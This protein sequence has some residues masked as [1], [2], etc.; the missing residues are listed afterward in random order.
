MIQFD[1]MLNL[2]INVRSTNLV[3]FSFF[4]LQKI[5]DTFAVKDLS[6]QIV[7][8]E[9]HFSWLYSPPLRGGNNGA[10]WIFR[11]TVPSLHFQPRHLQ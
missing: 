5:L 1:S 4:V 7:A 2:G 9:L 8:G 6:T 11:Q 10:R 3:I